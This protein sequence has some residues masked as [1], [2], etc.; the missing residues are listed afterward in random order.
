[1]VTEV[2]EKYPRT[3]KVLKTLMKIV[4]RELEDGKLKVQ[5]LSDLVDVQEILDN[6]GR[7]SSGRD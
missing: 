4:Q 1:M 6:D 3:R 5:L 7:E 2:V